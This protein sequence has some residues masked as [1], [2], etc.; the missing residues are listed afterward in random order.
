MFINDTVK[1]SEVVTFFA[2]VL[3]RT[4]YVLPMAKCLKNS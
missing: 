3:S 2:N 1:K 4:M